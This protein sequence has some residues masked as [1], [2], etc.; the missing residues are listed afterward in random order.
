MPAADLVLVDLGC[1]LL[2]RD[3][4]GAARSRSASA[5]PPAPGHDW[6]API[7][8]PAPGTQWI[9]LRQAL[10]LDPTPQAPLP[11]AAQ[12]PVS[13]LGARGRLLLAYSCC[14][15]HLLCSA[16][17]CAGAPSALSALPRS[18]M[19]PMLPA[20]CAHTVHTRQVHGGKF[21]RH[22]QAGHAERGMQGAAQQGRPPPAGSCSQQQAL[23][24]LAHPQPPA[25]SSIAIAAVPEQQTPLQPS[26]A[27]MPPVRSAAAQQGTGSSKAGTKP[28]VHSGTGLQ[29]QK[30]CIE[31]HL[32]LRCH[33]L[34]G[35]ICTC[36][37]AGERS[38]CQQAVAEQGCKEAA[39]QHR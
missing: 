11:A 1:S 4:L 13:L 38:A 8:R 9:S 16:A 29:A 10:G 5:N 7:T 26:R 17:P 21:R 25:G 3:D 20:A 14:C 12:S 2:P 35:L 28:V 19:Q 36:A 15:E 32:M 33:A 31:L 24:Q 6:S 30:V 18:F 22:V 39:P 23:R 37:P 34:H 27:G